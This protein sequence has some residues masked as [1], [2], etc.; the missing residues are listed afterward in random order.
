M[1]IALASIHPRPLSGQIEGLVGLARALQSKGHTVT[2][3]SAFPSEELMGPDR[4]RL[5]RTPQRIIVDQPSRIARVLLQLRRVAPQVDV[6]QLNLPTPAFSMFAD[7]VQ[8]VVKV[9]VVVGFEAHLV[10]V[11]DIFRRG[12]VAQS[13]EFYLPRLA[14]NNRFVARL[15]GHRARH[16]VVHSAFQEQELVRLGVAPDRVSV[17]PPVLPRDKVGGGSSAMRSSFPPGRI[18]TYLGHYNHIKGVDVLARAYQLLAPRHSDLSLAVAWSGIGSAHALDGLLSDP[19]LRRRVYPLGQ[20]NVPDLLA[21]SDLVALPYRLTIGQAAYP[22]VLLEAMMARVP[23]VTTDLPLLRELTENAKMAILVPPDDP[24]ALA[25]GIECIL[26]QP[27]VVDRL[28]H[29]QDR[30]LQQVEPECVVREYERLYQQV[31]SQQK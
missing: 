14:I 10:G 5:A 22:A 24:E 4:L 17:L 12:Y 20:V 18:L 6:I 27:A 8:A 30:W 7:V 23:V 29:A 25:E 3:V 26:T 31:A 11:R 15:T 9:P 19:V 1:R 13:P 28:K 2:L 16:Y 21:A